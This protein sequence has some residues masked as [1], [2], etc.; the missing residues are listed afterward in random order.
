ML[1]QPLAGFT[2][3]KTD[4]P[5]GLTATVFPPIATDLALLQHPRALV[6]VAS[7]THDLPA[8]LGNF[9]LCGSAAAA[10]KDKRK[11]E[12]NVAEQARMGEAS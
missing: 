8:G 3:T 12:T 11:R 4:P 9:A 6:S 2:Y 5:I 10:H 7:C 1:L